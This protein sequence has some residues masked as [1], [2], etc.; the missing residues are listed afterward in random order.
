MAIFTILQ[1]IFFELGYGP[2]LT[3]YFGETLPLLANSLV[4]N[5]NWIATIIISLFTKVLIDKITLLGTFSI[6]AGCNIITLFIIYLYMIETKGIK[7]EDISK[8][9]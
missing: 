5:I 3:V 7:R 2:I 8:I 6:F 9:F 1:R 4:W